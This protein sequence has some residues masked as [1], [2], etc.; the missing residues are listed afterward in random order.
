MFSETVHSC[1]SCEDHFFCKVL[2]DCTSILQAS[3]YYQAY[4]LRRGQ[5]SG[6]SDAACPTIGGQTAEQGQMIEARGQRFEERESGSWRGRTSRR[7]YRFAMPVAFGGQS[8]R[9]GQF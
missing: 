5:K 9:A 2:S 3:N 8:A 6:S 7:Q 4:E 1:V